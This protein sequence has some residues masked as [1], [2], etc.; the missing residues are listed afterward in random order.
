MDKKRIGIGM[1]TLMMTLVWAF[2]WSF[3]WVVGWTVVRDIGLGYS[4]F[5]GGQI[6]GIVAG[7]IAGGC[8]GIGTAII[9]K[10]ASPASGLRIYHT[11]LLAVGWV[12]IVL[13][14]WSDGFVV[15]APAGYPIESGMGGP[16][17]GVLG[18]IFTA[19]IL[20]WANHTLTW[21]QL[22]L[23]IGG[24]TLGFSLAGFIAWTIGF[25][26]AVS[27]VYGPIYHN[28]PGLIGF[29]LIMVISTSCGALAGWLGGLMTIRQ[30]SPESLLENK[31][32]E[33]RQITG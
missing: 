8:G 9:L 25:D 6:G 19:L 24:W 32:I 10:L 3:S 26:I 2:S 15:A 11:L 29:I 5:V 28:D 17:S 20:L 30:L 4:F 27:Y 33:I 12:V 1:L 14:D 22:L 23:I 13:Y 31:T 16:L 7:V 18:G 21:K